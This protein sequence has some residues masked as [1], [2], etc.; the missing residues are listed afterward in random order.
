MK[1]F[2]DDQFMVNYILDPVGN[3]Q[4]ESDLIRW[5]EWMQS[6]D[7]K[8]KVDKIGKVRVST[9]FLGIDH[10]FSRFGPPILWETM[11][12]GGPHDQYQERYTSLK[13]AKTGHEKAVTLAKGECDH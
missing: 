7:R 10:N 1:S 6:Q 4:P 9:V 8:V 2:G 13:A 3:P 12:F 11:I 5:A